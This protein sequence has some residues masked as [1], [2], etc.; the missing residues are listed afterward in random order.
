[1]ALNPKR[2]KAFLAIFV[3]CVLASVAAASSS[4]DMTTGIRFVRPTGTQA[5]CG[6]KAKDALN[7]FLL[8][9]QESPPG[10]GE[11]SAEG[12]ADKMTGAAV[13]HC[14]GLDKGYVVTLTCAVQSPQSLY[15]AAAL[16]QT[17]ANRFAGRPTQPLATPTPL[18]S[19]CS[20]TNLV[21]DWTGSGVALHMTVENG[22]L[23]GDG[24]SGSWYLSGNAATITY[25]GDHTATLSADGKHLDGRDYHLTRKC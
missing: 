2:T 6:A 9:A 10:S 25:Y 16:C 21:G 20:L 5:D 14:I 3:A 4:V 17:I 11:W 23:G 22:L 12:P 19:G 13:L 8:D 24:V 18:P 1:M 15:A 7:A